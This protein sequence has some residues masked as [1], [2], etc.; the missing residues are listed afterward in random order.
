MAWTTD[1]CGWPST[2]A[3]LGA[4]VIA[5]AA[6]ARH[7]AS[8]RAQLEV[9]PDLMATSLPAGGDVDTRSELEAGR[10]S[11]WPRANGCSS[12]CSL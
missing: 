5:T 10:H 7:T 12:T 9:V 6:H 1:A 4:D 3:E 2:R 8:D 11:H